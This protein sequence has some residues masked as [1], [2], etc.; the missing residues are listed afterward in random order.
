VLEPIFNLLEK[1][2][3]EVANQPAE[4]V[5][6]PVKKEEPAEAQ[7]IRKITRQNLKGF[8]TPSIKD[9]LQGKF[10]EEKLTSKQLHEI[11]SKDDEKEDFTPELLKE[12]WDAF[13]QRLGDRPNLQSTL[14]NVPKLKENFQLELEIENSLQEDI[15]SNIKPELL[16]WLRIELK[17]SQVQLNT[18]YAE[19]SKG[20]IIYS[21][22]EKFEEL[23]R[24][25]EALALLRQKFNLDF[26]H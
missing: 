21:D 12:K 16:T 10:Q 24:K 22:S 2:S 19:N 14:A 4:V 6:P 5:K 25:N 18:I 17:N 8:S 11:F 3:S 20:R 23:L 9:A 7:E 26:G 1:L 13:V 15:I